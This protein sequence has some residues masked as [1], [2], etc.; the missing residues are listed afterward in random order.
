[1]EEYEELE[2]GVVEDESDEIVDTDLNGEGSMD[3]DDK[4]SD[5]GADN[6]E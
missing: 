3:M 4:R 1:M 5:D 6:D 2:K